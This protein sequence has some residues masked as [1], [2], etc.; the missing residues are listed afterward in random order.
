M[1]PLK[2]RPHDR[3]RR[4]LPFADEKEAGYGFACHPPYELCGL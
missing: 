3:F 4:H 1:G 2:A